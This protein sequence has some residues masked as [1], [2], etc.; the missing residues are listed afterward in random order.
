M[1]A[2]EELTRLDLNDGLGLRVDELGD[3]GIYLV[4]VN[5]SDGAGDQRRTLEINQSLLNGWQA[6]T[7]HGVVLGKYSKTILV[8]RSATPYH[9]ESFIGQCGTNMKYICRSVDAKDFGRR[10]GC[11]EHDSRC[12]GQREN[13]IGTGCVGE[14]EQLFHQFIDQLFG[15]WR[16]LFW[17]CSRREAITS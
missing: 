12:L 9:S 1:K 17:R 6:S 7:T 10:E 16:Q 11:E 14:A 13:G 4:A 8:E 5:G 3:R 15:I 2:T